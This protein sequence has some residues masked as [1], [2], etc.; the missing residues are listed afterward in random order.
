MSQVSSILQRA[1]RNKLDKLNIL[2]YPTHERYASHLANINADFYLWQ[3]EH[4][5]KWNEKYAKIPK[6]HILLNPK[7]GDKQL[8]D[9][10]TPD[11]IFSQNKLAHYSISA[12]LAQKYKVPLVSL[13]HC[14]PWKGISPQ[15]LQ[16]LYNMQGNVNVFISD[17]SRKNWGFNESNSVVIEHGI[18]YNLFKPQDTDKTIDLLLVGNDIINRDILLGWTEFCY[19]TGYPNS[20][21]KL[22]ILGSNPGISEPAS[23]I[24]ELVSYYNKSK[25]FI[26]PA[27]NSPIPYSLI[28][29]MSCGCACVCYKQ[30]LV[31]DV[32]QHNVNG[33]IS[34]NPD[35]L[36]KY[37]VE[38]L[39]DEDKRKELGENARKLVKTR[40]NLDRFTK[41]WTKVFRSLT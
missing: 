3:G 7:H 11:I 13:E 32:I 39:E 22:K 16:Q 18:D 6:N 9:Y 40:F 8:P 10:I 29:A 23:S 34:D 33:M 37:C 12:K 30:G 24:N 36:K 35:E 27:K 41:D 19:I 38:L 5:V 14:F 2:T 25:I 26:C 28:E 17:I 4:T 31:S 15:Q 20:P 1:T 21:Y